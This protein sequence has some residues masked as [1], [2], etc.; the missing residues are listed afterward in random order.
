MFLNFWKTRCFKFNCNH[1]LDTSGLLGK[2]LWFHDMEH[3]HP[4]VLQAI[5]GRNDTKALLEV[6]EV[7]DL[8]RRG[9]WGGQ[10]PERSEALGGKS[11]IHA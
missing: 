7:I 10:R 2:M 11:E 1:L 5:L 3:K 4:T 8:M 6:S 9:W